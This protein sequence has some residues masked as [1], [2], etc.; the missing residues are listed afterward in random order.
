MNNKFP[1]TIKTITAF[2]V[3]LT[4]LTISGCG[5]GSG[6]STTVTNTDVSPAHAPQNVALSVDGMRTLRFEWD[7]TPKANHF[8]INEDRFGTDNYV[9]R[10]DSSFVQDL[11]HSY[12]IAVHKE[13]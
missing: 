8:I 1:N 9:E 2:L 7:F 13:R 6:G 10:A 11:H 5:G 3:L 4:S 12:E